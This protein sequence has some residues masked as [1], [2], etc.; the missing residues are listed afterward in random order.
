MGLPEE[1]FRLLYRRVGVGKDSEAYME[2]TCQASGIIGQGRFAS[3]EKVHD[4]IVGCIKRAS[5]LVE[6][7]NSRLRAYMNI[8]RHRENILSYAYDEIAVGY[9]YVPDSRYHH[10]WVQLFRRK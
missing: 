9:V 1:A 2:I 6:N 7:V 10:Y 3:A 4:R 5:S 8:K